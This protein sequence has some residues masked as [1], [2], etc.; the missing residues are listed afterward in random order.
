MIQD[1]LP[2]LSTMVK[3]FRFPTS[4]YEYK[5]VTLRECPPTED[6]FLCDTP[7]R[8]ADYW[9]HHLPTD[10]RFNSEVECLVALMVNTRRRVKGH[11]LVATGTVDTILCHA[12]EVFRVAIVASASAVILMHNH[13]S[14][15]ASP[16]EA[17]VKVTR[18]MIRAGQ[19][20]RIDLL[21][22]IIMGSGGSHRSLRELG[23]FTI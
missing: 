21:D 11:Y 7:Q 22:H 12:R 23:Y 13:P 15:D 18:D 6:Q 19:L 20:L 8:A 9:R 2:G 5:L 10:P 17:D 14:G 3:P 16:S 1:A 4:A